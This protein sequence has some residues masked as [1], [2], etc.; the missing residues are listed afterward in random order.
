MLVIP[1]WGLVMMLLASAIG[2]V[3]L[4]RQLKAVS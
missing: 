4:F 2:T 1:K 3:L